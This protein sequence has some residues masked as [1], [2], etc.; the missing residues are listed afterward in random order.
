M[1]R[2][3][4]EKQQSRAQSVKLAPTMAQRIAADYVQTNRGEGQA[5]MPAHARSVSLQETGADL[6]DVMRDREMKYYGD[7]QGRDRGPPM[8]CRYHPGR[9]HHGASLPLFQIPPLQQLIL[10]RVRY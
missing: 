5:S 7:A 4:H 3:G 1:I 9:A 6:S 2:R 8:N 10:T